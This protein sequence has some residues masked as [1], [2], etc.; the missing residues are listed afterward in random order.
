VDLLLLWLLISLLFEFPNLSSKAYEA[1]IILF[2]S[3][4]TLFTLYWFR[5]P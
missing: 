4:M 2:S 5:V 3:K 1:P